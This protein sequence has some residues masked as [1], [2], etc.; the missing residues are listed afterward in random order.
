MET[1]AQS[2]REERPGARAAC[3]AAPTLGAAVIAERAPT[4]SPDLAQPLSAIWNSPVPDSRVSM[5]R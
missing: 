3:L 2:L 4:S 5:Q 1:A